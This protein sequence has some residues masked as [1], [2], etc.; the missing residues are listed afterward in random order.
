MDQASQVLEHLQEGHSIT[1]MD[2]IRFFGITRI[3]ARI[4]QLKKQGHDIERRDITVF[5]KFGRR[6]TFGRWTLANTEA[7]HIEQMKFGDF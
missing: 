1:S 4:H 2:A 7:S 3:S 6:K 5:D